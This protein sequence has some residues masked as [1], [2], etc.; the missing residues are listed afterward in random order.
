MNLNENGED[1]D[2]EVDNL[3]NVLREKYKNKAEETIKKVTHG[4]I[5]QVSQ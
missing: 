3:L 5:K 2:P 4:K 1:T